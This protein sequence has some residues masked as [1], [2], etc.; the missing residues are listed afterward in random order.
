MGTKAVKYEAMIGDVHLLMNNYCASQK[1]VIP[2]VG[3]HIL[4]PRLLNQRAKPVKAI[5]IVVKNNANQ[6]IKIKQQLTGALRKKGW[7]V[8]KNPN[9][10]DYLLQSNIIKV[11]KILAPKDCSL[12]MASG[13]AELIGNPF[14]KVFSYTVIVDIQIKGW[15]GKD[16]LCHQARVVIDIDHKKL[17]ELKARYV[18]GHELVEAILEIF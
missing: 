15:L 13:G 10:A 17:K 2:K 6:N 7:R 9:H 12:A 3:Q 1:I 11:E 18:I 5:Y 4:N 8:V 16:T 14:D